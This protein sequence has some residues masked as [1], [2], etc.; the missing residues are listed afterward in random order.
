MVQALRRG[1][2]WELASAVRCPSWLC[3][4]REVLVKAAPHAGVDDATAGTLCVVPFR[5]QTSTNT[6]PVHPTLLRVWRH[7]T[8]PPVLSAE[9]ATFQRFQCL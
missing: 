5:V 4:G 2:L 8:L 3:A 9:A 6:R 7:T 1:Q